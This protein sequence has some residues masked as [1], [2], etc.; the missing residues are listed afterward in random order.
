MLDANKLAALGLL[1]HDTMAA[2]LGAFSPSA[3][4]LLL[5]LHNHGSMTATAIAP[6]LGVAQPTAV[7]VAGGLIRQGLV[8]ASRD[9]RTA[10]LD[11]TRA[12]RRQAEALQRARLGA[13][14]PLLVGLSPRKRA[15]LGRLV[16]RVLAGATRSEA[17]ARTTCRLCDHR[18]CDGPRCPIGTEVHRIG[19]CP[20]HH[21]EDGRAEKK[22]DAE[23]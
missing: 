12:G 21:S 19:A 6:I 10:P 13:I 2:A 8:V 14:E 3:A 22:S 17:F 20:L 9:G 18:L 15:R 7:R 23:C 4:A 11:L 1:V 16:D 5:T